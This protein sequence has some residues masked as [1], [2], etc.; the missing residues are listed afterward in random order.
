MG[1]PVSGYAPC[2]ESV[3]GAR[4]ASALSLRQCELD[5]VHRVTAPHGCQQSL[6]RLSSHRVVA[7]SGPRNLPLSASAAG[8]STRFTEFR[9]RPIRYSKLLR[10]V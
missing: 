7:A 3:A 6:S 8:S 10:S 9:L 1:L 5:Q 4:A 2:R